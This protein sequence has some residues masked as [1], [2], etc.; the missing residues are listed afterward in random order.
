MISVSKLNPKFV[1]VGEQLDIIYTGATH[2]D[3]DVSVTFS[4][5]RVA[6]ERTKS[7]TMRDGSTVGS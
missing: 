6:V 3:L 1:M 7:V 4:T 5:G 2:G